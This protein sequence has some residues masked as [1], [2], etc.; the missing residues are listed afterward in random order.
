[1]KLLII[2]PI[3]G[4]KISENLG[5]GDKIQEGTMLTNDWSCFENDFDKRGIDFSSSNEMARHLQADAFAFFR[6]GVD[7]QPDDNFI[8]SIAN[9]T[10]GFLN[11]LW[12]T[13]DIGFGIDKVIVAEGQGPEFHIEGVPFPYET[14][15]CCEDVDRNL[16]R[17]ELR[18]ARKKY[19][20]LLEAGYSYTTDE[21]HLSGEMPQI[22]RA[23]SWLALARQ[24]RSHLV[25]TLLYITCFETIFTT[26]TEKIAENLAQRISKFFGSSRNQEEV[27][28][29]IRDAYDI[30]S[31]IVHG[32]PLDEK[33]YQESIKIVQSLDEYLRLTFNELWSDPKLWERMN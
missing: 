20:N 12:F 22:I 11:S 10:I 18:V 28:N 29:I 31:T 8:V 16:S 15:S 9:H 2:I 1:M 3:W 13:G 7:S 24:Q 27:Y 6:G 26:F 17:D 33:T 14:T 5:R 25:K 19:R 32:K 21:L 4:F 30:R 23:V